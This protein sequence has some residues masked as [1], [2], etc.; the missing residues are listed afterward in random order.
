MKRNLIALIAGS[1][2]LITP[3]V[4]QTAMAQFPSQ[5]P[6]AR[7]E[8]TQQLRSKFQQVRNQ[9]ASILSP[10]QQDQFRVAIAQ[11]KPMREAIAAMNLSPEQQTQLKQVLQAAGMPTPEQLNLTPQQEA[12][13]Y[14]IRTQSVAQLERILSPEQRDQVTAAL[15]EGKDLRSAIAAMNLT[16]DQKTQL[17]QVMQSARTQIDSTLTPDQK[18]Q[19]RQTFRSAMRQVKR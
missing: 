14:Q 17:R 19:L 5:R 6:G 3:I 18:Q 13:L 7:A 16:P 8:L 11:G 15:V 12:K 1:V 9:L 4:T 2:V 10:E